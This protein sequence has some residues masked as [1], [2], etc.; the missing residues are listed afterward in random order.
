M[1]A[2]DILGVSGREILDRLVAGEE[3]AAKLVPSARRH[4]AEDPQ[5]E[6]ALQGKFGDHH[7][8]MLKQ[9]LGHLDHLDQQIAEFNGESR[10]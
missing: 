1:V 10:N 3:D 4:E 7:R 9:L 5:L 6:L 2:S 8:F